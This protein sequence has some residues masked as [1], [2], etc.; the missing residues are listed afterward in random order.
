MHTPLPLY[1]GSATGCLWFFGCSDEHYIHNT[2]HGKKH[3]FPRAKYFQ[4]NILFTQFL[5]ICWQRDFFY[6]Q[7][8]YKHAGK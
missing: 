6:S 4:Q 5:G 2:A 3:V 8:I 1:T 7:L